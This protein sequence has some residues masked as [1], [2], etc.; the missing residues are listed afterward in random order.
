MYFMVYAVLVPFVKLVL[1]F[2]GNM[3]MSEW[4]WLYADIL[5][6][7]LMVAAMTFAWPSDKLAERR[8]TSALL[9]ARTV[10]TVLMPV[11]VFV[12]FLAIAMYLLTLQPFYEPFEAL[13]IQVPA[14]EWQKKGDNYESAVGFLLLALQLPTACFIFTYGQEYR[15]PVCC[16]IFLFIIYIAFLILA[17]VLLWGGPSEL[18]C[19]FRV[20][21]DTAS[22][23]TMY[24]PGIQEL[25][26]G[27]IGGCFLGSQ[28]MG[29]AKKLGDNYTAPD[30]EANGCQVHPDHDLQKEIRTP[31]GSLT[32]WLGNDECM[33]PNNCFDS[34]FRMTMTWLLLAMVVTTCVVGKLMGMWHPGPRQHFQKL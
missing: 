31:S 33:G 28:L 6:G 24:V 23:M 15:K 13:T 30:V 25:S 17:F 19:V 32:S 7:S 5:V 22:S 20:N 1:L 9:N 29:Y 3:I 2:M 27:N 18:H 8:P 26:T 14:H 21:C 12:I 10:S 16:N 4:A 11:G 34:H